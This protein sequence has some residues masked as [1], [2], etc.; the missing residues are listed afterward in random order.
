M[1]AVWSRGQSNSPLLG[2][3][4]QMPRFSDK[5]PSIVIYV[6]SLVAGLT[7]LSALVLVAQGKSTRAEIL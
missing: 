2:N 3:Q 5:R 6:K 1:H 7:A 4:N